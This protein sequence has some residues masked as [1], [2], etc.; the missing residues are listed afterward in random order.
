MNVTVSIINGKS[1]STP[2]GNFTWS[3]LRLHFDTGPFVLFAEGT[4]NHVPSTATL[5]L[6]EVFTYYL[7][8][9]EYNPS[10]SIPLHRALRD[11]VQRTSSSEHIQEL[12]LRGAD[13]NDTVM[14][15]QHIHWVCTQTKPSSPSNIDLLLGAGADPNVSLS[16]CYR[17]PGCV[18]NSGQRPLHTAIQNDNIEV[19]P[20]LL[21]AGASPFARD[22]NGTTPIELAMSTCNPGTIALFRPYIA[23]WIGR[24]LIS[25]VS[26]M[27]VR[28]SPSL[29][30]IRSNF[31]C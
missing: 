31:G 10:R 30:D 26:R 6:H 22:V 1:V 28:T 20:S 11:R 12:L 17:P 13:P 29:D 25:F 5:P 7:V 2:R 9:I 3:F 8:P 24:G 16:Y 23:T 18:C 14:G 4:S 19:I 15:H 27:I 21:A